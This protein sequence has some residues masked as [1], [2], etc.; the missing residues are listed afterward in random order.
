[1]GLSKLKFSQEDREKLYFNQYM[2]RGTVKAKQLYYAN[3]VSS[4]DEYKSMIDH[5][6]LNVRAWR[7]KV[8]IDEIDFDLI[9]KIVNF[10]NNRKHIEKCIYRHEGDKM[11]V[12]TNDTA[13]LEKLLD[14]CP[15]AKFTQLV[16]SPAG[17]KYFKKDP[18]ANYRVYL[19]SKRIE[20]DTRESIIDF[21]MT[22]N[23][24]TPSGTLLR[25]LHSQS[26]WQNSYIN[27]GQ[28]IDFNDESTLTYMSLIFPG[29]IGKT[30][31]LEK[32]TV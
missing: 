30:Y 32:K 24:A 10:K 12:F 21:F 31:K 20:A 26:Q 2:Y 16:L 19:K 29:I 22:R 17:V 15:D 4:F 1:M 23:I 6:M 9:E 11:A 27:T 3:G 7:T 25:N 13:I 14:I 5:A 8:N 28:Y 18:P